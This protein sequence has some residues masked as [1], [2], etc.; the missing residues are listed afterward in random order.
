M[1]I[2]EHYTRPDL[3][4]TILDALRAAGRDV[5]H[6]TVEDLGAVDEFHIGGRQATAELAAQ[7]GSL[8]GLHLL[9]VGC[10]IGG[11]SR[12]IA[13]K[14]GCHVT[15]VDLTPEYV[16]TAR[17]LAKRVGLADRL[18]YAEESATNLPYPAASFDGAYMIHVG[19]NVQV[20]AAVCSSIRRVVRPGGFFAIYDVMRERDGELRY[21][22]P[23]ASEAEDS[24]VATATEYR[25]F[26]TRAGF[27]V[28][29]ERSRRQFAIDFFREMR[30]R[31]GTPNPEGRPPLDLR[32]LMGPDTQVKVANLV[33]ALEA[34]LV[35]PTEMIAR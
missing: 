13:D 32:L 24:F 14:Y 26:L 7:L 27:Q 9:D 20:K 15:G 33:A 1:S 8:E 19:M 3:E 2:V 4:R 30:S 35:S 16:R 34:G 18:D 25:D 10:G 5:D 28:V 11:P 29:A 22:L 31:M 12:F 23:W 17:N 21:P 6:L